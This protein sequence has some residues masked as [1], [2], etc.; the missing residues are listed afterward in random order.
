M[1]EQWKDIIE[2]AKLT[3]E[4]NMLMVAEH[5]ERM[6]NLEMKKVTKELD[7]VKKE[8]VNAWK[9]KGELEGKI[10]HLEE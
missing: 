6:L 4:K 7:V 1:N 5:S 9:I 10:R 2:K 8:K 3:E